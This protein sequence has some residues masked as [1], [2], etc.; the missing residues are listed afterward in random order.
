M[1][2]TVTFKASLLAGL[3]LLAGG[4]ALAHTGAADSIGFVGGLVH[5]LNG[6]D[7]LLAMLAVG[8]WAAQLGQSARWLMPATFVT[9]M[10]AGLVLAQTGVEPGAVEWALAA[11]VLVLGLLLAGRARVATLIGLTAVA[12]LAVVHGLAHGL[13]RPQ[14]AAVLAY[15][16]GVLLTTGLLHLAGLGLG[17]QLRHYPGLL[18]GS[19]ALVAATGVY[20]LGSA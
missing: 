8:V 13:E 18:R 1:K 19:G 9:A 2:R 5:P 20:L 4:P 15:G 12:G 3:L 14:D 17:W 6:L 11:S 16:A 7:H 10:G